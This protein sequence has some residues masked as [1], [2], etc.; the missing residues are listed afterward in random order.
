MIAPRSGSLHFSRWKQAV[1]AFGITLLLM[2]TI[3]NGVN[4]HRWISPLPLP[5]PLT[6]STSSGPV[7]Q[8]GGIDLE[9]IDDIPFWVWV[10]LPR[11]F[12]EKLPGAGGYTSLGLSWEPGNELPTGFTKDT[13]GIPHVVL[14]DPSTVSFDIQRY[15]QFLVACAQDPRFISNFILPEITYNVN[16]SAWERLVYRV[17][18]IPSTKKSLLAWAK[19]IENGGP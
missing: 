9:A 5:L 12:P 4:W 18:V 11:L 8:A 17:S 3:V 15:A 7:V 13:S 16:L 14:R 10:V 2:F 19:K 6:V 1:A